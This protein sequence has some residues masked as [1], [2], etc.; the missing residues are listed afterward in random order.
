MNSQFIKT[1]VSPNP[2]PATYEK[3]RPYESLIGDWDFDWV[4]QDQDGTK[5]EVPGEWFFS[6]ILEGRA[7]QDNWI[8]PSLAM[9][10]SGKYPAGQYGTTIRF[11]DPDHDR[12]KVVWFGAINVQL[13][14]F[15]VSF[16]D[17]Q[18]IQQEILSEQKPNLAKWVFSNIKPESFKWDAYLSEDSGATW[19]LTQEVF[20]KRKNS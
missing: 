9:R 18:I 20:A 13:Y 14:V 16:T 15:N 12:V 19:R 17:D 7:I 6:W 10:N 3:L 4:G 1:L 2:H 5:M 8:C 11:Y